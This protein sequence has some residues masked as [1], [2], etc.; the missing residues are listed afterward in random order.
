[1]PLLCEAPQGGEVEGEP[2][3]QKPLCWQEWAPGTG[4]GEAPWETTGVGGT[5]WRSWE[6]FK[7]LSLVRSE[8]GMT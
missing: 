6:I 4:S 5:P 2:A 1:M 3:F 7:V 8:V